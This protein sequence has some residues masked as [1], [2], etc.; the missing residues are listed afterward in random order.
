MDTLYNLFIEI[1][2]NYGD[3]VALIIF[4]TG[5]IGYAIYFIIKNFLRNHINLENLFFN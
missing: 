3:S 2:K 4:I 1:S 5:G